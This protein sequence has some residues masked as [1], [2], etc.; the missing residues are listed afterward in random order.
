MT[1]LGRDAHPCLRGGDIGQAEH[2]TRSVAVRPKYLAAKNPVE[3]VL[4]KAKGK[5]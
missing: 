1:A 5:S 3:A 2:R 4:A